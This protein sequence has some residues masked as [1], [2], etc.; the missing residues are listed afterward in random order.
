MLDRLGL[1]YDCNGPE[2]LVE[3][4]GYDFE[5]VLG[6]LVCRAQ[7]VR[8]RREKRGERWAKGGERRGERG[9]RRER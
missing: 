3:G 2:T 4:T 8:F 9:E 6:G 5:Y 7:H 1:T